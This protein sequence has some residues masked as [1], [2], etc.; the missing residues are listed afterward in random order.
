VTIDIT[1]VD[2]LL[3]EKLLKERPGILNRLLE[4]FRDWNDNAGFVIPE[5]VADTT[6]DFRSDSDALGRFLTDCTIQELGAKTSVSD[7]H[8]ARTA[9]AKVNGE[10]PWSAKTLGS[11]MLERGY[12]QSRADQ[13]CWKDLKLVKIARDF[14]TNQTDEPPEPL[15]RPDDDAVV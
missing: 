3:P 6:E 14:G 8:A 2:K 13:R 10:P 11:A 5:E 7:L 9:W 15:E 12:K 1:E 4:G